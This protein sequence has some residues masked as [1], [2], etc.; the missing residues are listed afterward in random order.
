MFQKWWRP[1]TGL[2]LCIWAL[3]MIGGQSRFFQD[4]GTF[5]HT[6]VGEQ[7]LATGKLIYQDTFSFTFAGRPWSP[8]QWLGECIMAVLQRVDELDTLLLASVTMLACLYTWLAKRLIRSGLHWSLAGIVVGLTLAASSSHFHIRPHIGT[9]VFTGI[10]FAFLCDFERGIIDRRSFFWLIP[11]F[12]LWANI[13][14]GFL[15]GIGTIGMALAAWCISRFIG[16][17]SPIANLRSFA[18]VFLVFVA[19]ALSAYV[20][21]YGAR[22]PQ[23]WLEIMKADLPTIIQEHAPLDPA[24]PEGRMVLL[25]GLVYGLSLISVF[26]K[27]PRVTWLLPMIWFYL[28]CT[29]IRHAPLFSITAALAV[30]DMAPQ[31]RWAAW[32]VRNGSDWFQ[33]PHCSLQSERPRLVWQPALLPMALIL[34]AFCLQ[35]T[36]TP[37]PVVGHGWARLDPNY[38]PVEVLPALETYQAARSGGTPIFN[39]Y[40]F[41]G[42][43]IYKTPGFKVFVDDRCELYGY[44]WLKEYVDAEWDGTEHYFEKWNSADRPFDFALTREGSG[45]DHYFANSTEWTAVQK[46]ETA[47]VYRRIT[48]RAF[49]AS[50]GTSWDIVPAAESEHRPPGAR[51]GGP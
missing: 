28:S 30:A 17:P 26:P 9:I 20:N 6:V 2:F 24:R 11:I 5:W 27:W 43:L 19:C 51:C 47:N 1:E 18:M 44:C 38:W 35:V 39:E 41:G 37:V 16:K 45:F 50:D 15:G 13:H 3:L 4:P 8:H 32:L 21:P 40:L 10:T 36:R 22:L 46:T 23:I 31:T 14:G 33:F 25:F 49:L 7:M 34:V 29:R 12:W 42:F 48:I